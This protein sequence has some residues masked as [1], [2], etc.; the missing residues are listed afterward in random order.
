MAQSTACNILALTTADHSLHLASAIVLLGN[1]LAL[2]LD[3]STS[4]QHATA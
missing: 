2:A 4:A 1:G 3:R